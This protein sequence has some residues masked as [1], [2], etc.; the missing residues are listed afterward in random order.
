LKKKFLTNLALL[1]F[2]NLLIKPFWILGIDRTVQNIVGASEYGFYFSLLSFSLLLNILLDLGI[3]NYNNRSIAQNHHLLAKQFSNI[4]GL[5]FLLAIFYCIISLT[6]AFFVGYEWRQVKL[7]FFLI[8]NQF[9]LSFIMYL[10]SNLTGLHLFKTDSFVS[11]LDRGLMILICTLLIWGHIFNKPITIEWYVLVQTFSYILTAIVAFILVF[12]K[13][14]FVR[15]N[16]NI[17]FFIVILRHSYPYAILILLMAFYN[18]IDSVMLERLLPDGNE[19]AGIYAQSFRILDAFAMFAFLFAGMLLPIFAKMIKLKESVNQM[20]KLAFLLLIVPAII[21]VVMCY[22]YKFEIMNLMYHAH[23]QASSEIFGVLIIGFLAISMTYIFGT[24]LTANGNLR[25]LNMMAS[26]GMLINIVLNFILIPRYKAYGAAMSSL[27]TQSFTALAQIIIAKRV[28]KFVF[29]RKFLIQF[30]S[31]A[32]GIG[33][34]GI[35]CRNYFTNWQTGIM[36]LVGTS[37]IFAFITR[38]ISIKGLYEIIR[39]GEEQGK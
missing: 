10:R 16:V 21:V 31:F 39:F 12:K 11:V 34:I 25:E 32:I 18:R 3:T 7:L 14:R 15:F 1:L 2:L 30:F 36:V 27:F 4:V 6:I 20:V 17:K 37:V 29:N 28:F 13:S 23:T 35:F 5:K 22:F 9:L 24:L 33:L 38:V 8:F 19:Q 26:L